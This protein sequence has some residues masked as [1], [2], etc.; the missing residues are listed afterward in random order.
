MRDHNIE[1][2]KHAIIGVKY[3][4]FLMGLNERG[5]AYNDLKH[6]FKDN[7]RIEDLI[8]LYENNCV[9]N[10]FNDNNQ[11]LIEKAKEDCF[12]EELVI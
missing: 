9:N 4:K 10:Q 11:F 7:D 3:D 8:T 1:D 6:I 5:K 2:L 12:Y